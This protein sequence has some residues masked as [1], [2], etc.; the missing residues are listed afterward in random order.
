MSE[1][2]NN[3]YYVYGFTEAGLVPLFAAAALAEAGLPSSVTEQAGVLA[4]SDQAIGAALPRAGLVKAEAEGRETQTMRA[5]GLANQPAPF[6]WRFGEVAAVLRLVSRAEFCGPAGET[7]LQDLAWLAPRACQHQAVLEQVMRLGPVLPARFGTL[8]SSLD[9]LGSFLQ[10]HEAAII[11]FL[12]RVRGHEEWAVKGFLDSA[13]A[14]A[15]LLARARSGEAGPFS[16]TPGMAYLQEQSLRIKVKQELENRVAEAREALSN[17]LNPLASEACQR[18]ILSRETTGEERG[19]VLNWAFLVPPATLTDFRLQ[20]ER[21]NAEPKLAGL[22]FE[23]SGPWPP[24]SF[25]PALEPEPW[26]VE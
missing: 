25:C 5:G 12:E 23:L 8:F 1:E 22:A 21:A 26:P 17:E 15:E 14:E 20:I 18:R 3:V 9:S 2:S 24:Y 11:Q 6:F 13:R 10:K 7:N 19:M 16:S 4:E